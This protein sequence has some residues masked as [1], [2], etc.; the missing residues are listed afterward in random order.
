M[1][2]I[3]FDNNFNNLLEDKKILVIQK[4]GSIGGAEKNLEKIIDS[5]SEK[6]HVVFF[7]LGPCIGPFFDKLS[8]K[9]V[10]FIRSNLPDW[11]KGKNFISRYFYLL[12]HFL[13]LREKTF[14]LI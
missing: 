11:R 13:L 4:M 9:N 3:F 6:Y 14:D 8:H 7:I 12:R 1:K 5:F 10:S 2:E